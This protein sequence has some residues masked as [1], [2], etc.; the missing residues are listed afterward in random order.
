MPLLSPTTLTTDEQRLILRAT[1][2]NVRGHLIYSLALGTGLRLAEIVGRDVG[3]V[4]APDGAPRVRVRVRAAIAKGDVFH[5]DRLA[6]KLK[7]FWRWKRDR[8]ED[9]SPAAASRSGGSSSRGRRGSGGRGSTG[10]TAFIAHATPQ[11]R[12]CTR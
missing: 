4:F 10:S 7:R 1:A 8:G 5:P 12:R 9:L 6:A 3:D 2:G 11:F